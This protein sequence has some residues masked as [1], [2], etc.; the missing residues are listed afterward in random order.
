[1]IKQI[2]D[3]YRNSD[4]EDWSF[5]MS[6]AQEQWRAGDPVYIPNEADNVG[7][8]PYRGFTIQ[9]QP[10]TYYFSKSI[11]LVRGMSLVG[12][13]GAGFHAGT[14]FV[15][16]PGTVGLI[17]ERPGT[18]AT[19]DFQRGEWS[20]IERV[21]LQAK[22]R[23]NRKP[24]DKQAHGVLMNG[25]MTIRDCYIN[26]FEGDGIHMAGGSPRYVSDNWQASNV[27]I[28]N[29]ENGIFTE[30]GDSSAGCAI[31]IFALNN[32]SWGINENS[33]HGNTYIAC[34]VRTNQGGGYRTRDD[35]NGVSVFLNCYSE[36]DQP[37][38]EIHSPALAIGG[39]LDL[40]PSL[41]P[42]PIYL[43]SENAK[44]TFPWGVQAYSKETAGAPTVIGMLG[45]QIERVALELH[46]SKTPQDQFPYRLRYG[47]EGWWELHAD[48]PGDTTRSPIRFSTNSAATARERVNV[49]FENG[50]FM[51][52]DDGKK[53]IE[54]MKAPPTAGD[55]EI[56]DQIWN[57]SPVVNG[58][59][60]WVYVADPDD[61]T[62]PGKYAWHGFGKIE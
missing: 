2:E 41:N 6:W 46:A 10:R 52:S 22:I 53:K 54:M 9:F 37:K 4:K 56:G 36:G 30:T 20:I 51:G 39:I 23:K 60:G 43:S 26:G 44:A 13:G 3:F 14:I 24:T 57:A 31:A 16:E 7:D 5:A 47:E 25:F 45:S 1:M 50:Y 62:N 19:N 58:Y 29:C 33:Q 21:R 42:P 48:I 61:P 17:C 28:S 27:V 35:G 8:L 32:R 55:W 15:F 40:E 59:I 49:W 12:S 11:Q 38:S 34:H 18:V